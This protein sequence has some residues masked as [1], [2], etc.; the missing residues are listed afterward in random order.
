[1]R[2]DKSELT[3]AFAV[4][5]TSSKQ[6]IV[7]PAVLDIVVVDIRVR[8]KIYCTYRCKATRRRAQAYR[9]TGEAGVKGVIG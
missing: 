5:A 8:D 9:A 6:E 3:D 4:L 1:M 7:Q 2:Y